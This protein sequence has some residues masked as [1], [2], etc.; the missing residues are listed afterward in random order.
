MLRCSRVDIRKI[1][2][3]VRGVSGITMEHHHI[4]VQAKLVSGLCNA[5]ALETLKVPTSCAFECFMSYLD[6]R[7]GRPME[8]P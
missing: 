1:T 2:R 3:R 5:A 4:H 6:L 8:V 7:L